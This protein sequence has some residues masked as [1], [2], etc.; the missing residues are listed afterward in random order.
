MTDQPSR[1]DANATTDLPQNEISVGVTFSSA[2]QAAAYE[3][4]AKEL[5]DT[6]DTATLH[7]A[8]GS[9]MSDI[10]HLVNNLVREGKL[11]E[12]GAFLA[13]PGWPKTTYVRSRD[14]T[15]PMEWIDLDFDEG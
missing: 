14:A 7:K 10:G 4:L 11:A 15:Y 9:C 13:V 5:G 6:L 8:L 3:V 2:L 12:R 1:P